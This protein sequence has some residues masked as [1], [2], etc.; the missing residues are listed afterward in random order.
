MIWRSNGSPKCP[1]CGGRLTYYV[2]TEGGNGIKTIRY[3]LRCKACGYRQVLQEVMIRKTSEGV[4]ISLP[5][6]KN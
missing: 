5:K 3:V 4:I 1:R 2:E 6:A